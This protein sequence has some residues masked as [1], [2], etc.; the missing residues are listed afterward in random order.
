LRAESQ[1]K[2][3]NLSASEDLRRIWPKLFMAN[4]NFMGQKGLLVESVTQVN[5]EN[6]FF[7]IFG[8]S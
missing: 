2:E 3:T 8:Q 4:T 5:G 6:K 1:E 7:G